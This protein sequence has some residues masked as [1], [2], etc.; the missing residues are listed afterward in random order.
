M[1][2]DRPY[3]LIDKKSYITESELLRRRL[4]RTIKL[5]DEGYAVNVIKDGN[6]VSL[7]LDGGKK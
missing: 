1:S 3:D 6:L 2:E 5:V 4:L 7:V